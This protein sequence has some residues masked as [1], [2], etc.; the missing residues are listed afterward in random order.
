MHTSPSIAIVLPA[1]NE[2]TTIEATILSF[3]QSVPQAKIYV[4]NNCS[5]DKT[6]D[7]AHNALSQ[8]TIPGQPINEVRKG[9]DNSL[10]AAFSKREFLYVEDTVS[11]SV[12]VMELSKD[13]YDQQ[14]E[15]MQSHI[16]T[17]SG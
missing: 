9:K 6:Q 3:S 8:L 10:R 4:I 13:I 12:F 7:I 16:N 11:A 15:P 14:T 1:F 5:T 2:A 17:G